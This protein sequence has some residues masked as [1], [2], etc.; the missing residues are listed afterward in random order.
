M[1]VLLTA[2]MAASVLAIG[3]NIEPAQSRPLGWTSAS[4]ET[5][6]QR[7]QQVQEI[8]RERA[9]ARL[10]QRAGERI[11]EMSPTERQRA[12]QR[13]QQRL[14]DKGFGYTDRERA[15][16]RLRQRAGERIKEMSP[17]DR[18]RAKA[19]VRERLEAQ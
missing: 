2:T 5:A 8:D 15:K 13:V 19:R 14:D 7:V 3:L 17:A 12:R 10:R 1:R 18:E 6:V 16:A 9:K 11:R 4:P